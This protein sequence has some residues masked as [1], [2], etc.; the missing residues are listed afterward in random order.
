M[1]N[2]VRLPIVLLLAVSAAASAQVTATL[3]DIP[4]TGPRDAFDI[5]S[6][7][8][9]NHD[10]VYKGDLYVLYWH[11]PGPSMRDDFQ[12][13]TWDPVICTGFANPPPGSS[14]ECNDRVLMAWKHLSCLSGDWACGENAFWNIYG[15]RR[16]YHTDPNVDA[17]SG[18]A[19]YF[20]WRNSGGALAPPPVQQMAGWSDLGGFGFTPA[21]CRGSDGEVYELGNYG[22]SGYPAVVYANG[23]W[24]MA[25][26]A[27]L[28]SPARSGSTEEDVHRIGWA[29]SDD[30][31]NWTYHGV[32]VRDASEANCSDGSYATDLY[33]E[34]GSFYL[35]V[36]SISHGP[37]PGTN[38]MYLLKAPFSPS[39]P[40]GF[41]GWHAPT[42]RDFEDNLLYPEF[43]N[44]S[45][46][47]PIDFRR[48]QSITGDQDFIINGTIAKV[49]ASPASDEYRYV[50]VVDLSRALT[51]TDGRKVCPSDDASYPLRVYT[52]PSL[53]RV[54]RSFSDITPAENSSR[55]KSA[56]WYG[57]SPE[58]PQVVPDGR[59]TR[60]Y[61]PITVFVNYCAA[62]DNRQNIGRV[63]LNLRGGI[64]H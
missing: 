29:T 21:N 45:P 16:N 61:D 33:F 30:G 24:F 32:I 60:V 52:S 27:S 13:W 28:H 34:N 25:F 10:A 51:V 63:R 43:P 8:A 14:P 3:E 37:G 26:D 5:S 56:G 36:T 47:V 58:I 62:D 64:Y 7:G 1:R 41:E 6:M 18:N 17:G 48:H 39:A 20:T 40:S 49:Y 54:F 4:G 44:V 22:G 15:G 50:L 38:K 11:G 46:D 23:R 12:T 35:L 57:W 55:F 59:F 2:P 31:A 53:E 42:G 19:N 9:Y